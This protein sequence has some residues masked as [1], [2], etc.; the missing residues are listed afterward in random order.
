MPPGGLFWGMAD[1]G[2]MFAELPLAAV[3]EELVAELLATPD[4]RVERIVSTGQASPEHYWYDQEWAEWVL[5]L[6]GGARLLFEDEAE[7]RC[8][9]PGDYANIPAHRR[10]RVEWTDPQQ[11]TVWLAVHYR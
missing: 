6:R 8:L 4:L 10:H 9:G 11:A 1:R 7:P 5:L 3:A 2:N